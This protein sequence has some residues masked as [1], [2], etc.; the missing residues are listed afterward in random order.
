MTADNVVDSV[1]FNGILLAVNGTLNDWKIEKTFTFNSC[2]QSN[3]GS[4]VINATDLSGS[5]HCSAG[6][7]IMLCI[8]NDTS[9]PWHNFFTDDTNW[10]NNED[11]STPCSLQ[12]GFLPAAVKRMPIVADMVNVGAKKIWAESKTVSLK[13]TP[14]T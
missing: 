7:L 8:A 12:N 6:G 14:P 13:G 4:L 1:S 3:P 2:D 5:N 9:S 11:N 10:I